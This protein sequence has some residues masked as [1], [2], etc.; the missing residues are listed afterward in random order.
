MRVLAL[1]G[2]GNKPPCSLD[3]LEAA[4]MADWKM[5]FDVIAALEALGHEA[6]CLETG[7]DL[8]Q[9]REAI[10]EHKPHIVFNMLEDFHGH[11]VF[12]SNVV[13]YLELMRIPYTGCNPRGLVLSRDKGLTKKICTY[14]RIPVPGFAVYPMGRRIR[15]NSKLQFPLIVKALLEDASAGI[16]GASV[17]YD[18][19]QLV[20]RV[21]F[22]H[23]NVGD[24]AIAEEY[25]E[26]R[27]IYLGMLGNDRLT[28]F[29]AWELH[30]E[31]MPDGAPR[32][33]TESV[34]F[35]IK[36]Q[37]KHEILADRAK[38]LPA[39]VEER[40]ARIGKRVYRA[41]GMSGYGRLDFRVRPD[42]RM[43][44]LEGNA[45]PDLTGDEYFAFSAEAY[46]LSYEAMIQ[47]I[48]NLGL[49]YHAGWE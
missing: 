46:G 39:G 11:V 38:D 8:A 15:K 17:V 36:Y 49:R 31:N 30:L 3:G 37:E 27:E 9:I 2:P 12:D 47:R 6:I 41:L 35:N 26:G 7:H 4:D 29:P 14:H 43:F 40:M 20:K 44:L 28:A 48:L 19:V 22:V 45:N 34:K 10:A 33:A 21:Q 42:G 1:V 18:E 16:S 32:I 5:E 23:E 13:A 25:I 24:H